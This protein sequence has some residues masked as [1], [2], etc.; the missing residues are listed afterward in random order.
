MKK[1]IPGRYV[2]VHIYKLCHPITKIP[3]YIGKT[4]SA[5][6]QRLSNHLSNSKKRITKK[7]IIICNLISEGYMPIIESIEYIKSIHRGTKRY[8]N[9]QKREKYWIRKLSNKY[10]IVNSVFGSDSPFFSTWELHRLCIEIKS[11]TPKK[12]HKA[13][14]FMKETT[15]KTISEVYKNKHRVVPKTLEDI[16]K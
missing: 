7:D 5:L 15:L 1:F 12:Y 3:F 10:P 6:K 9:F 14:T 11:I 13:L 4:E 8:K 16:E 2:E